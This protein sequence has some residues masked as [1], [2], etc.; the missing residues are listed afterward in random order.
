VNFRLATKIRSR[1]NDKLVLQVKRSNVLK[2]HGRLHIV[3]AIRPYNMPLS[4]F[5]Y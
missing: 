4:Y 1:N 2:Y 5:P 3:T